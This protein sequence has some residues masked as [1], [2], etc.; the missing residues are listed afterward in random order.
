[1]SVS[2]TPS[3]VP[4]RPPWTAWLA[5]VSVT[6]GIFSIVTTEI[7]PIGLL[8]PIGSTF[9]ISDGTAGLMMTT[10]GVL[11]AIAAPVVT[12]AAGRLDRRLLL[13]ALMLVL[14]CAD[15]LAAVAPSYPVLMVSRVLVG[16]VIGAFWSIAAGLAARLVPP[17]RVARATA[18][19]FSAVPL[20]SVLG[21]PAGTYV[22][23]QLGWRA[24][25]AVLGV[26][27]AGVLAALIAFVPPLPVAGATR[28]G[29]LGGLLR[30]RAVRRA[31]LV[32]F[33]IVLAHFG[34]YTYVTPLLE[35]VTHAGP[36]LI[37]VLLFGYGVAGITGN[38]VAGAWAARRP[39]ATFAAGALLL[40]VATTALPFA[41]GTTSGAA[42]LLVVWGLAYG[43]VPVCSQTWFALAAP[44]APEAA[45]VLFTSSF[46]ATF[47]LGAFAGGVLVDMS[48]VRATMVAGGVAAFATAALVLTSSKR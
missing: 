28:L 45:S 44:R 20:G 23:A 13:G 3:A 11:A 47:S 10:P 8:T 29:A 46:Q 41:G 16:V 31:L 21:V 12:G 36:A 32:T 26:L 38:F 17:H 18:V 19:I 24:T 4:T 14:A 43:V 9:G 42:V 5:V 39:R 37:T 27:T 34:T 22:G 25:F 35:Q 2:T 33:L 1:M 30:T 15:V 7:M 48:S 40:A 6:L